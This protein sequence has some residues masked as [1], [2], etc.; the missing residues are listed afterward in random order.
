MKRL[1]IY[2]DEELD[3]RLAADALREGTSKAAL[4]REAVATRYGEK[5]QGVALPASD[6]LDALV[7]AIPG[8]AGDIDA[9]LYGRVEPDRTR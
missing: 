4:I 6:P 8:D 2:L 9:L 3:E 5:G 1:Q 7:A